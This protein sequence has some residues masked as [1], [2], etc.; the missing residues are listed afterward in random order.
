VAAGQ[1]SRRAGRRRRLFTSRQRGA[2]ERGV[3]LVEVVITI[4][5]LGAVMVTMSSALFSVIKTSDLARRQALAEVELRHYAE[6]IRQAPYIPC[7]Q[8]YPN[9]SGYTAE[10][11]K[12]VV[13]T[14]H[15]Y[16]PDPSATVDALGAASA[17]QYWHKSANTATSVVPDAWVNSP[18]LLDAGACSP[19]GCGTPTAPC[20]TGDDGVQKL[21]IQVSIAGT[22]AVI[23]STT[24]I[25]RAT[26]PS[27]QGA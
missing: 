17:I 27:E 19:A 22:P 10:Y 4:W 7:A 2:D 25:K 16:T 8:L 1:G 11:R 18:A 20:T 15:T 3:T 6:A 21:T 24:V 13:Q 9:L 14:L 5:I 23:K 26:A 12:E